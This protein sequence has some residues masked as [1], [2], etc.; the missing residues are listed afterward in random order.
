MKSNRPEIIKIGKLIND[1]INL[2]DNSVT[3]AAFH[4]M[5]IEGS[6]LM[7]VIDN[8]GFATNEEIEEYKRAK[9]DY[10]EKVKEYSNLK[11]E[12]DKLEED[13]KLLKENS[14][15]YKDLIKGLEP[16]IKHLEPIILQ[17]VK[18]VINKIGKD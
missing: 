12:Y 11:E 17:K 9:Y 1:Y 18:N 8:L 13:S 3:K 4:N 2:K 5:R 16:L 15:N 10:N 14:D 7:D 6:D